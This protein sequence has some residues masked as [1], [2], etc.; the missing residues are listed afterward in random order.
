MAEPRCPGLIEDVDA[1]DLI[2]A[3]TD[4]DGNPDTV[5]FG[6]GVDLVLSTDLDGD[7]CLDRVLRIG[8]DGVAREVGHRPDDPLPGWFD[9]P[10]AP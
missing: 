3:D 8:P 6:D 2:P 7:G 9:D 4:G 10:I 5:V 1:P